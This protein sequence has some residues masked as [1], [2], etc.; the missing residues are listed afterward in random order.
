MKDEDCKC[1]PKRIAERIEKT[2]LVLDVVKEKI[3]DNNYIVITK[4]EIAEKL[5]YQT[6]QR[7][8]GKIKRRLKRLE[9][10]GFIKRKLIITED[11]KNF[12][13]IR[14]INKEDK[15]CFAE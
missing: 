6:D 5:G 7:R 10:N 3:G 1:L 8:L 13:T 14:V 12:P 2:Q 9:D 15:F 4:K 11:G